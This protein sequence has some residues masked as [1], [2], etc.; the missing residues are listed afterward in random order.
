MRAFAHSNH[1]QQSVR[2]DLVDIHLLIMVEIITPVKG[3][4]EGLDGLELG[5]F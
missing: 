1:T 4:Q 3:L 2:P 5:G